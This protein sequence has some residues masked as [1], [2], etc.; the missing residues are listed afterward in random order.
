[1]KKKRFLTTVLCLLLSVSMVLMAGCENKPAG[2]SSKYGITPASTIFVSGA[3]GDLVLGLNPIDATVSSVRDGET[4]VDAGNYVVENGS[5]TLKSDYLS[6]LATGKHTFTVTLNKHNVKVDVRI[7]KAPEFAVDRTE[8]IWDEPQDLVVPVD[9]GGDNIVSVK[10]GTERLSADSF[11]VSGGNLTVNKD[12]IEAM[13]I[14]GE[15]TLTLTTNVGV[16]TLI[17]N[18]HTKVIHATFDNSRYKIQSE[19]G[20]DV[21]FSFNPGGAD[22]TLSV[23]TDGGYEEFENAGY[24]FNALTKIL[25]IKAAWLDK[26]Y[27]GIHAFRLNV[28]DSENTQIDFEAGAAGKKG[29]ATLAMPGS[30]YSMND[31]DTLAPDSSFGGSNI[32]TSEFFTNPDGAESKI[33]SGDE[34]VSGNSLKISSKVSGV[35]WNTLFGMNMPFKQNVLYRFD[36]KMKIKTAE[37]GANPSFAFRFMPNPEVWGLLLDYHADSDSFTISQKTDDRTTFSYDASTKVLDVSVYMTPGASGENFT[38][39][40]VNADK[41]SIALDDLR[42]L[43][44]DIPAKLKTTLDPVEYMKRGGEDLSVDLSATGVKFTGDVT[45]GDNALQQG[46][47]YVTTDKGLAIK[48]GAFADLADGDYTLAFKGYY[49]KDVFGATENVD[50]SMVITVNS[51]EPARVTG[52]ALKV[53]TAAKESLEYTLSMGSFTLENITTNGTDV[54]ADNYALSGGNLTLKAEY[55]NTLPVGLHRFTLN[56]KYGEDRTM[57][58]TVSAGVYGNENAH[59]ADVVGILDFNAY[60]IGTTLDK[61]LPPKD[62]GCTSG[63]GYIHSWSGY[64][65]KTIIADDVM[66]KALNVASGESGTGSLSYNT[67]KANTLYVIRFKFRTGNDAAVSNLL[68]KWIHADINAS[69]VEGDKIKIDTKDS[70]TSIVKDDNNVYTWTSYL[71][72]TSIGTDQLILWSV[73]P[74]ELHISSIEVIETTFESGD[75]QTIPV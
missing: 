33:V 9:L 72:K 67:L 73:T 41:I 20:K 3:S 68:L 45:L 51:V 69:W 66:G 55:L 42:V 34:A 43:K 7:Y 21:S 26:E 12:S 11:S 5:L 61:I 57:Q 48:A 64:A 37:A 1:M 74:Q 62:D 16:A 35:G 30:V 70:R 36:M 50:C 27:A 59:L 75:G 29:S 47:G 17:I 58:L 8:Y 52:S 18:C 15:N 22:F 63:D 54:A 56:L 60:N 6:S 10:V 46:S 23:K 28:K 24:E 65:N 25:S 49:V 2:E 71:P 19:N 38:F 4:E 40:A 32:S 39:T 31:F 13:C 14:D 53:Q 44:T